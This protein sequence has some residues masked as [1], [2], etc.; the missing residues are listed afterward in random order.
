MKIQTSA[1]ELAL[2]RALKARRAAHGFKFS[3]SELE[4]DWWH[5][6]LRH[7]D[8][9]RILHRLSVDGCI[10][11]VAGQTQALYQLTPEGVDRLFNSLEPLESLPSHDRDAGVLEQAR[12][13][14]TIAPAPARARR[15]AGDEAL[16]MGDTVR[17]L[18]QRSKA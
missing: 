9:N 3:Y 2:Y 12:R 13:R 16:A 15:R 7:S 14:P 17:W 5:T 6:G 10:R 4:Q 1:L 18:P 11:R 8:L